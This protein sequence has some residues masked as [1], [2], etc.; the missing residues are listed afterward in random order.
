MTTVTKSTSP[1]LAVL[2]LPKNHVPRLISYARSILSAVTN[3]PSFPSPR[4]PL[5]TVEGAIRALEQAEAATLTRR[6]GTVATRDQRRLALQILLEQL[7]GHVQARADADAEHGASII[8]SAGMAV[9]K[10]GGPAPRTF[11]VKTGRVSGS[12]QLVAP[13][14]GNRAA[15]EWQY[16]SDGK[17]TWMSC[18]TTVQATTIIRGLAPASSVFFRY[19]TVT[20]DGT[21]DWSDPLSRI[22]S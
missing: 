20:K 8:E 14:A 19:R 5:A 9:R 21:S 4:P 13:K 7:R 18:P 2:K 6:V 17:K 3:N 12:V 1:C 11:T 16:S 22:V 10:K 15:Y